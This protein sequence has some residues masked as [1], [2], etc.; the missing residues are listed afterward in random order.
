VAIIAR[1][2]T[3]DLPKDWAPIPGPTTLQSLGSAWLRARSSAVL[4]V[5]SAVVER[6]HNILL[7]P[8]HPDFY[9]IA[10]GAGLPFV[11]HARL[12][13]SPPTV[14]KPPSASGPKARKRAAGTVAKPQ[15]KPLRRRSKK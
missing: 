7:N 11:F 12:K 2:S 5:P 6:E 8:D 10:I 9:K 4:I 14:A 15:K 1:P 13:K 3:P